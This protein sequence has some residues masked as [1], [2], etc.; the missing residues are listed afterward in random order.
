MRGS[1]YHQA[2]CIDVICQLHAEMGEF[3]EALRYFDEALA[4]CEASGDRYHEAL[5]L[6]G[7]AKAG[8]DRR[9]AQDLAG[10]TLQH[11]RELD[12]EEDGDVTAFLQTLEAGTLDADP[13]PASVAD[14]VLPAR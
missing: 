9:S 14:A 3:S 1:D 7:Q 5:A 11:F 4:V 12:A 10:R 6:F 2:E 13:P 8:S